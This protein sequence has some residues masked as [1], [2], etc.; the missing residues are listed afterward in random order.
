MDILLSLQ[1]PRFIGANEAEEIAPTIELDAIDEVVEGRRM[2]GEMAD[3]L[4]ED[5]ME[6]EDRTNDVLGERDADEVVQQAN[7]QETMED[8][9]CE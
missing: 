2:Q 9:F 3:V 4:V 8:A 1:Q 7:A 5:G 6:F